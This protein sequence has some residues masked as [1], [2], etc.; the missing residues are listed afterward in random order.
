MM[1]ACFVLKNRLKSSKL[2]KR[3]QARVVEACA[4]STVLFDAQFRPWHRSEINQIRRAVDKIY[5][6][7]W[8]DNEC[9]PQIEMT[10]KG[11]NM[12][13][14]QEQLGVTMIKMKITKR[15]V[16]RI[17]HDLRMDNNRMTKQIAL[18]WPADQTRQTK[19]QATI[20]YLRKCL[21]DA[22]VEP[23]HMEQVVMNRRS[24]R[25]MMNKRIEHM[26]NWD[27]K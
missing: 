21:K 24:W 22:G 8:S 20:E 17:G 14:V 23:D 25:A 18:G 6:Y 5:R 4:E 16:Q 2:T 27:K 19:R 11:V 13:E 7:I 10:K 3:A 12:F 15:T 26:K 9:P 1:K